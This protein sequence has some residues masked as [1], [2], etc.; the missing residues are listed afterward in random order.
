MLRRLSP[1]LLAWRAANALATMLCPAFW[2]RACY[3]FVILL[4]GLVAESAQVFLASA[5]EITEQLTLGNA[6][7]Q[8]VLAGR[9]AGIEPKDLFKECDRA[10]R[11]VHDGLSGR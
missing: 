7:S 1:S 2:L 8:V 10:S 5:N 11:R 4:L 3:C 6:Y 9:R